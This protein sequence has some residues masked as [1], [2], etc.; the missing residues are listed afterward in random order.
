[1]TSLSKEQV[2][3][4]QQICEECYGIKISE[5]EALRQGT[6]L[7]SLISNI[8][9]NR[10]INIEKSEGKNGSIQKNKN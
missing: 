5:V 3:K 6:A 8:L 1:M 2:Q 9:K 7:V 10:N 4:Y